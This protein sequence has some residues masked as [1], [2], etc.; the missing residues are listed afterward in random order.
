MKVRTLKIQ[1]NA[2]IIFFFLRGTLRTFTQNEDQSFR[3][4][5]SVSFTKSYGNPLVYRAENQ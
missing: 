2:C 3:Q 1:Y 4:K 5:K